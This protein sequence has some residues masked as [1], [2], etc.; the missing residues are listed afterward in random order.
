M[1]WPR[2]SRPLLMLIPSF[3][4]LPVAPVFLI[5]SEPARS[6]KWNLAEISSV[7]VY[8]SSESFLSSSGTWT[9]LTIFCSMVTV[10]I[11]CDLELPSFI[12]VE[13]VCLWLIPMFR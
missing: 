13:L 10:K 2:Q 5:L 1:T 9:S 6:T 7:T 8:G 4:S 11:A 12:S 3:R